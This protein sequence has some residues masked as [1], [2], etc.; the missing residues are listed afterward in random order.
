MAYMRRTGVSFSRLE[1]IELVKSMGVIGLAFAIMQVGLE[2]IAGLQFFIILAISFVTVGLGF[3]LH[4]LAH[5][6]I[7]QRHG[8]WA[9]YRGDNKMLLFTLILSVFGLL[10]QRR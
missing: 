10:F 2:G 8:C 3:L 7:A 9:E 1:L 6:I 4:E 5:K